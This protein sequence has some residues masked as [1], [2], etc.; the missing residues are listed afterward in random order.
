MYDIIIIGAGP[1]GY[2]AAERAGA[3]GKSVLLV[4]KSHL[5][6]VCLNR[7]CV[8]TKTLLHASKLF[9]QVKSGEQFGVICQN[10]RFDLSK[11]M[12]W[13]QKVIETL[14][15]GVAYQMKRHKVEVVQGE[16][17]LVDAKT[18]Q[19]GD[20]SYQGK[21]IIIATGSSPF[22]L[23]I[24]G[25]DSAHCVSSTELLEITKIPDRLII[26]GGGYIG[27]EFASFFSN[28]GVQVTVIEMMPEIIPFMDSEMS[29]LLRK[30]M[31]DV[32]FLLNTR[33]K[34]IKGKRVEYSKDGSL[35]SL[36][37]DLILLAVG[38][39]PNVQGNG[40]E[41]LGLDFDSKG[42][43]VNERMQTNIP[44]VYAIG[45]VTG[46]SLLA[47]SASRMG[48]IAVNNISGT[49]DCFRLTAIPWVVYTQPEIAGCGLSESEAKDSGRR[50]RTAKLS[51]KANSRHIAEHPNERGIC[52]VLIDEQTEALVGVQVLGS[53]VSEIIAGA[54]VMI[55]AEL[56]VKDVREIVFPHPTVSEIIKDTLWELS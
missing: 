7:G 22:K 5:G 8:P 29:S 28:I 30:A 37:A 32:V 27:M 25:I 42:V 24:P 46:Q 31:K 49:A 13:K 33:V 18:V 9:A 35:D 48:E 11:A 20:N 16:A 1:G 50:V 53:G 21:N 6:G 55:E 45:D 54:S 12:E 4:E 23:P 2:V 47:H 19:V 44:G 52:K 10:S 51:L 34:A 36:D 40:F 15:Q 3:A 26:I 14:R 38:R 39:A 43:R 17:L 56:R 41:K